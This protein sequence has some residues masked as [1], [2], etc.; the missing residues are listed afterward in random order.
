MNTNEYHLVSVCIPVF[1]GERFILDCIN[2]VLEQSY[3]NLELVILDNCSTDS[4]PEIVK[5]VKDERIRYIKNEVNIG[6]IN[7][8]SKCVEEARGGYFV[9]LPHDDM[10]LPGCLLNYVKQL[11][12]PKIGFV[13]SA[14][15]VIDE[16]GDMLSTKINHDKDEIYNSEEVIADIVD[17]FVPIQLTMVRIHILKKLGGFDITYGLFCDVNLWLRVAL[18][19]WG[20]FYNSE[21]YSSH[22][23][24]DQQGQNAFTNYNLEV[25]SEHWGKKLDKTF[26]IEN[27]YNNL[28]LK[29]SQ[30]LLIEMKK[31][32][33]D[34]NHTKMRV[35][36]L[37]SDSHL[38]GLLVAVA[39]SNWFVFR[40][41]LLL[42]KTATNLFGVKLILSSYPM[43]ILKLFKMVVKKVINLL[44]KFD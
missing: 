5:K 3:T 13:Y 32:G 27:S 24:H 7:N 35:L 16:N 40:Q 28:F 9:L 33:N 39:N 44:L 19:G 38:R 37:F 12:D 21:P 20:A 4:T 22:R 2:S 15:H 42:L 14:I 31:R 25:L 17:Y 1:N 34:I 43:A 8:F 6:A 11:E 18:D 26:W 10:L 23:S 41:E 36:K 29:L 30:F